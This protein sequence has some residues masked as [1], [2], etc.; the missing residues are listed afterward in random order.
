MM[1]SAVVYAMKCSCCVDGRAIALPVL[2]WQR[3]GSL[4]NSPFS[5]IR[6]SAFW[7]AMPILFS[8]SE[9]KYYWIDLS[10]ITKPGAPWQN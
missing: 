3:L 7:Q 9:G 1:V 2:P 8:S 4:V 10:D 5:K 6:S